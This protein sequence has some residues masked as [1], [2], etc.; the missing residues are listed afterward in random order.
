MVQGARRAT[1]A[2]RAAPRAGPAASSYARDGGCRRRPPRHRSVR[3]RV[4]RGS[5][6]NRVNGVTRQA[7]GD[8]H[9]RA[10]AC[11]MHGSGGARR[12]LRCPAGARP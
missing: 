6:D 5:G 2:T 4:A 1:M 7:V 10:F 11:T 9:G 3:R 8:R 12:T